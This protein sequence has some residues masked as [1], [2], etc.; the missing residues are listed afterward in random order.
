MYLYTSLSRGLA[1]ARP[2]KTVTRP[3]ARLPR[4]TSSSRA[5]AFYPEHWRC[6]EMDGVLAADQEPGKLAGA[7]N[8][9]VAGAVD[10]DRAEVLLGVL[11]RV[12]P[13][14]TVTCGPR[15]RPSEARGP[16]VEVPGL[17]LNPRLS[18]RPVAG[19]RSYVLEEPPEFA[20]LGLVG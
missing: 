8:A 12:E 7:A 11:E 14:Y 2:R 20:Q 15:S 17:G 5:K 9:L 13:E 1:C 3:S 19:R 16:P 10:A 18:L 6:G 4:G